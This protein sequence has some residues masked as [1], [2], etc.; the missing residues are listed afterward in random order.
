MISLPTPIDHDSHYINGQWRSS[1]ADKSIEIISPVTEKLL[2]RVPDA[3]SSD[4]DSAVAAAR[5]SF[6]AGTWA[7]MPATERARV[8]ERAAD[9]LESRTDEIAKL[10]TAE[11]GA[12]ITFSR[13]AQLP[14]PIFQFRQAARLIREFEFDQVMI[15]EAGSTLVS[16]EPV[17]VVAAI[18]PWNS[19]LHALGLK[20]APALAAGCSVVA[21][22]APETSL[23]IYPVAEC[24]HEA[25]LPPGIFN[26]VT[27]GRAPSEQL[28]GHQ[29]VDL[30]S[31]TGS[32][33]TGASIAR[34][35]ADRIAR[36]MLELGGKSASI[37][38]DDADFEEAIAGI[39]PISMMINGQVCISWSRILV[40]R[41]RYGEFSRMLADAVGEL[42]VGDPFDPAISIGPM[43][44]AGHR[45][46]VEGYIASAREEGATVLVGGGRPA[47]LHHGYFVE[48]TVLTEVS[49]SMKV[50]REE[51]FG[52]VLAVIAYDDEDDAVRIA[53]AS[54]FGLSGSVWT[55]NRERGLAVARRIRTGMVS[56]NGASQATGAPFGGYKK[57]GIGREDGIEGLRT[58]LE[59]KSIAG[60]PVP[61]GGSADDHEEV[62]S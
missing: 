48:P 56:I 15:D 57:S 53:N 1:D 20:I 3:A 35:C 50:A 30:V 31:F 42:S 40:P 5:E 2:G 8:L 10:V 25:G 46:R 33:A 24:L 59:I 55:Q 32:T 27:G 21:K 17:G 23:S 7:T 47:H 37:I 29:D 6:E 61:T 18:T 13:F 38:L 49:N 19:P 41:E 43:V 11:M 12:T 34:T 45:D 16:H 14:S 39:L 58:F 51:V 60:P 28:V 36:V 9:L 54:E 44:S 26:F 22:P 4:V 52:P 62:T